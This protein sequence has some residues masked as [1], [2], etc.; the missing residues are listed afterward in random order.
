M[1]GEVQ[2]HD[3]EHLGYGIRVINFLISGK[4]VTR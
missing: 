3:T 1:L 2:L 4:L